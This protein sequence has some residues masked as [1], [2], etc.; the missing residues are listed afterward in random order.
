MRF[1][2]I[3]L[4]SDKLHLWFF[5]FAFV[6]LSKFSLA[7]D[8]VINSE[9]SAQELNELGRS[10]DYL[11]KVDELLS[12]ITAN[13]EIRF[14]LIEKNT[15][16]SN[17]KEIRANEKK[18]IDL[19]KQSVDNLIKC[20]NLYYESYKIDYSVYQ[21]KLITYQ[22]NDRQKRLKVNSFVEE[23]KTIKAS[24]RSIVDELSLNDE[25][26]TI[27]T[28]TTKINLLR[29][30]GVDKLKE[31]FCSIL[32]CYE[33]KTTNYNMHSTNTSKA[34]TD[35]NNAYRVEFKI[36]IL[37]TSYAKNIPQLQSKYQINLPI[38]ETYNSEFK[39][40][41]YTVGN[42]DDY[43][44]AKEYSETIGISDAFVV[45][46]IDGKRSDIDEAILKSTKESVDIP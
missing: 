35:K 6:L 11:Q 9:L 4:V 28:K 32:N 13:D 27:K 8:K 39:V 21:S 19:D 34:K 26:K 1:E 29:T 10:H 37:A 46:F 20:A 18:I 31:S 41:R 38:E 5:L 24:I 25:L 15:Q 44:L 30:E 45:S 22:I 40:Y 33:V 17:K 12:E 43:Y 3:L 42:F 14:K 16:I 23:A 7:Q 36:Q 2:N